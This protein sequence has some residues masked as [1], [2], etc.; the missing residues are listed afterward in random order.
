[1]HLNKPSKELVLDLANAANNRALT[2]NDVNITNPSVVNINSRNT[3]ALALAVEGSKY[4]G[5]TLLHYD[6]LDLAVAMPAAEPEGLEVM[7]PNDGFVDTIEVCDRLNRM[8]TL[9]LD[10][11]DIERLSVDT[12]ELPATALIRALPDSLGWTGERSVVFVPDRPMYADTFTSY[13][14][15]GFTLPPRDVS[16]LVNPM[17]VVDANV[18]FASPDDYLFYG[19]NVPAA[20]FTVCNNGE[21]EIAAC[22]RR[23]GSLVVVPPDA[24]AVY[25]LQ[26]TGENSWS[27]PVSLGHL[28]SSND[29][30]ENYEIQ[31][32]IIAPDRSLVKLC[33]VK[34]SGNYRFVNTDLGILFDDDYVSEDG[35]VY[36]TI[37]DMATLKPH[38]GDVLSTGAG[39]P[40]GV[41][42]LR[43]Q[44][45]R[46]DSLAPRLLV[47][48]LVKAVN[49]S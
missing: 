10:E 41:F 22:A 14:L 49:G 16:G 29:L 5:S 36:Q 24:D 7:V 37:I 28:H 35:G 6:R 20:G 31:L 19:T 30:V 13:T 17:V 48:F 25:V 38:L 44:A 42:Q 33:L 4:T 2:L 40:L 12:S 27:V 45:R 23:N 21:L 34:D 47:S 3:R 39:A 11:T 15:D 8:F 9:H 43:L 1:M 46:K 26:L 32:E 18:S